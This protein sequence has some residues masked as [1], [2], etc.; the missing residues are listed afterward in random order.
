MK[1]LAKINCESIRNTK[2]FVN[3]FKI[4]KFK[5]KELSI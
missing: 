2:A 4:Y 5:L 3:F 1:G